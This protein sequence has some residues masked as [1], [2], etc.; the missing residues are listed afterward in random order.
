[1][2]EREILEFL[3]TH[4]IVKDGPN[5]DKNQYGH[6]ELW[7]AANSVAEQPDAGRNPW[8]FLGDAQNSF[9]LAAMGQ[10]RGAL[11]EARKLYAISEVK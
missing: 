3:A 5:K 10:L 6:I 1:M 4:F 9:S 2:T 11:N 8:M 7:W